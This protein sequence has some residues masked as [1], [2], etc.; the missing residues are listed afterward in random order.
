[1]KTNLLKYFLLTALAV[2]PL[3]V[4]ASD[5]GVLEKLDLTKL[6]KQASER[7]TVT[8]DRSL[9]EFAVE[10]L[11]KDDPDTQKVQNLISNLDGIYVRCFTFEDGNTY[12][13]SDVEAIRKQL[14][15]GWSKMVEVRGDQ[16]VDFYVMRDGKKFK[17]FF[18][19]S[20]EPSQV[21]LVNIQ[22][23]ISPEQLSQ[24]EGF[25]GIPKGI[26]K[27]AKDKEKDKDPAPKDNDDAKK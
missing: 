27:H 18:L 4:R 3:G 14:P 19:I 12:S 20:A 10:F 8:L 15:A 22:G 9:I 2:V 21:A 17:G 16:D 24:L 13:K 6:D 23:S 5:E 7:I 11:P 25:A 1:M 26:F